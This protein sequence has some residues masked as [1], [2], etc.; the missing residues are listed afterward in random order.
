MQDLCNDDHFDP[1]PTAASAVRWAT[2]FPDFDEDYRVN[3]AVRDI[4]E[5]TIQRYVEAEQ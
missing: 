4:T 5:D 2:P 1:Q 3:K